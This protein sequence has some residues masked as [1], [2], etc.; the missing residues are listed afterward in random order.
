MSLPDNNPALTS[1]GKIRRIDKLKVLKS[2]NIE[3]GTLVTEF[4]LPG[5]MTKALYDIGTLREAFEE[6]EFVE[7]AKNDI[8]CILDVLRNA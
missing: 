7:E 5:V 3:V 2:G 4:G 1:D 8:E 6:G